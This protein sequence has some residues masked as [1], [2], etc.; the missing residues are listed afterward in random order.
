MI[1]RLAIL[2]IQS[3]LV[4]SICAIV[5]S[6][7]GIYFGAYYNYKNL[8]NTK[9]HNK[10]TTEP[11]I[12]VLTET[13]KSRGHFCTLK[14]DGFGPAIIK[15]INYIYKEDKYEDIQVLYVKHFNTL[16]GNV[17]MKESQILLLFDDEV[18]GSGNSLE[19]VKLLFK[20]GYDIANF[21]V[22]LKDVRININYKNIYGDQKNYSEYLTHPNTSV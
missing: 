7:I 15:S 8:K 3:E 2:V 5:V 1:Y 20:E 4:I 18:L 16:R 11:F 17:N 12:S 14:N 13:T 22:F 19:L 6:V 10:R 9:D 21:V